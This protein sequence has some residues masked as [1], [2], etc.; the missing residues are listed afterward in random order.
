MLAPNFKTAKELGLTDAQHS[1][2]INVLGM[3]ERGELRDIGGEPWDREAVAKNGFSMMSWCTCIRGWAN[4][5]G[6]IAFYQTYGSA[7]TQRLFGLANLDMAGA[8]IALRDYLVT[9]KA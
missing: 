9:G 7:E 1:A 3:L 6:D 2:L 8:T 5:V 4:R